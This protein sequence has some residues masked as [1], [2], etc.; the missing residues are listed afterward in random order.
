MWLTSPYVLGTTWTVLI[1]GNPVC[2]GH[3]LIEEASME[4]VAKRIAATIAPA[5]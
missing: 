1:A 3:F 4:G 2:E 5:K